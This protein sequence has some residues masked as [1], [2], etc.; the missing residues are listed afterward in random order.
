M[1]LGKL[2]GGVGENGQETQE[3]IRPLPL[4]QEAAFYLY[5][6]CLVARQP[7]LGSSGKEE[8]SPAAVSQADSCVISSSGPGAH[9][10]VRLGDQ[11][12]LPVEFLDG[13]EPV[14]SFSPACREPKEAPIT[15]RLTL[16][17]VQLG[18]AI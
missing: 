5:I 4:K 15:R 6:L 1:N 16:P 17:W 13:T 7:G 11:T 9:I 18:Q 12:H 14:P 2:G 3:D 8:G 10:Q